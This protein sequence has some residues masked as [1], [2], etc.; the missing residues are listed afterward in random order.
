M[1][2]F[3]IYCDKSNISYVR[4]RKW[5]L[6]PINQIELFFQR[7]ISY[8]QI[9]YFSEILFIFLKFLSYITYI[10]NIWK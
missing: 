3:L 8:I 1:V 10:W 2:C 5:L 6:I 9:L 4:E 7:S